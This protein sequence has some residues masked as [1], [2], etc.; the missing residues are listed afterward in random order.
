M[1]F[2]L[3]VIRKSARNSRVLLSDGRKALVPN[4]FACWGREL[5]GSDI[6]EV[7]LAYRREFWHFSLLKKVKSS[8]KVFFRDFS[9]FDAGAEMELV[10]GCVRR[11][12]KKV[13]GRFWASDQL[14][15]FSLEVF[16][17]LLERGCF[18]GWDSRLSAYPA[19]VNRAVHNCLID[20]ARNVHVQQFR[21]AVSLN[22]PVR[23]RV[24][25]GAGLERIDFLPDLNQDL[26][27][28]LQA[29]ALYEAMNARVLKL[30]SEG[31]GL[32]GLSYKAIF[33]ALVTGSFDVLK[34]TTK[35]GKGVLEFHVSKL[36]KELAA[37]R[38]AWAG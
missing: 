32:S 15:D 33:N 10:R 8:N 22:A 18:R 17:R 38:D 21:N 23:D 27:E 6:V 20:I 34:V 37:V 36:R 14:D 5:D 9:S 31:A 25:E 16:L 26:V 28:Q 1:M 35:C 4:E 30:D 24:G 3:R 12:F 2:V 11:N 7:S 19:Y 29:N 13:F